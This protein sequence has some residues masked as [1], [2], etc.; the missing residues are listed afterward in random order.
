MDLEVIREKAFR[1]VG[2]NSFQHS[3]QEFRVASSLSE[4]YNPKNK[5]KLLNSY[6]SR[7]RKL[8]SYQD[9]EDRLRSTWSIKN[10]QA[11]LK[12]LAS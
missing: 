2:F 5:A 8:S 1:D 3:E 10:L 4:R 7:L 9:Y 12:E 6:I 11:Q